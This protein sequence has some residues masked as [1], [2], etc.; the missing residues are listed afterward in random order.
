MRLQRLIL[1]NFRNYTFLNEVFNTDLNIF[2][3]K[4]AQGKTNLVEAIYL[5]GLG[6]SYRTNRDSELIKWGCDRALV[7]GMVIRNFGPISVEIRLDSSKKKEILL[8]EIPNKKIQELL[9]HINVVIFS[10]EDLELVK[11][12]P[13]KRRDFLD[14]EISQ[15]NTGY[16]HFIN[17]YSRVVYQRN[18]LLREIPKNKK[19][20]DSLNVWDLQLID[21]GARL[22]KKRLEII[23]KLGILSRLM[24]RKI[25]NG[26]ETLELKY[27]SRFPVNETYSME[28]IK[29]VYSRELSKLREKEI[30]RGITLLGPHRDD[31]GLFVN[32][33][34]IRVY[35]SQGQQR[36]TALALKLAELE[37]MKSEV[38]E[39]PILLLDDVFSE[40]DN[41]R[42]KF[43][44]DVVKR[45]QTFVTLTSLEGLNISGIKQEYCIYRIEEGSII[46]CDSYGRVKKY[47]EGYP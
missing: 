35:G 43:L 4:N 19:L 40:L 24:H 38:G 32:N 45:V 11:G 2:V 31:L 15:I 18:N 36:T 34:D 8:N 44:M 23:K 22:V 21:L 29:E 25:T 20:I 6:K 9:G 28:D 13:A 1:Q 5:L 39:Y 7:N 47:I 30:Y 37:L 16:G 14:R 33:T 26:Q 42:R 46:R 10:P 3:G 41:T 17:M 12:S 27:I